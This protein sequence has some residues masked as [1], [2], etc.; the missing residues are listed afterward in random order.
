MQGSASDIIKLA[1]IYV[2]RTLCGQGWGERIRPKLLMQIHDELIY[3]LPDFFES[4]SSIGS[5]TSSQL[6]PTQNDDND[7][8]AVS[9]CTG[10]PADLQTEGIPTDTSIPSDRKNQNLVNFVSLLKT[11]MQQVVSSSLKLKVPLITNVMIGKDWGSM[12]QFD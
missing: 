6:V 1:M 9:V 11:C 5:G 3:E 10:I 8:T 7:R 4:V 2:E 12:H